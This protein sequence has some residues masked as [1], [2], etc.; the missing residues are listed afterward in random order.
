[1]AVSA[2]VVIALAAFW[3]SKALIAVPKS[4]AMLLPW[5]VSLAK[6]A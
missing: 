2:E 3:Q 1:M 5:L 4:P 6:G